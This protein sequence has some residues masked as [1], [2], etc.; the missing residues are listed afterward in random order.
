[1]RVLNIPI[2]NNRKIWTCQQAE[3][4]KEL[5]DQ[6]ETKIWAYFIT[7]P[8]R[9]IDNVKMVMSI[10]NDTERKRYDEIMLN[11]LKNSMKDTEAIQ[12][13]IIQNK[14]GVTNMSK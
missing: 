14:I 10:L 12:R 7:S 2:L 5:L 4:K 13:K 8:E 3:V 1:M 6:I 11:L 9:S